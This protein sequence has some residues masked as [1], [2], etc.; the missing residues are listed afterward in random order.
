MI[1]DELLNEARA[2]L[3]K[4]RVADVRIGLGYPAVLLDDGGCGLSGTL[5]ERDLAC[6]KRWRSTG[7]RPPSL[8]PSLLTAFHICSVRLSRTRKRSLGDSESSG[9][10]TTVQ[11]RGEESLSFAYARNVARKEEVCM[12]RGDGTGP[13][14]TGPGGGRGRG[15]GGGRGRMDGNRAGA[16]PSGSCVCPRCGE[17]VAHTVGTPC[18]RMTCPQCGTKMVRE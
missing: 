12:P 2:T 15:R 14:G 13:T 11:E 3:A 16:G 18:Y 1:V 9:R 4:Q 10:D 6:L 7:R 5:G 17:R 8:R